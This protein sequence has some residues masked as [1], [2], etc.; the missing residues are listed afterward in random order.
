MLLAAVNTL[1]SLLMVAYMGAFGFVTD[2][3]SR[4]SALL[5]TA[6]T[7]LDTAISTHIPDRAGPTFNLAGTYVSLLDLLEA[8]R[9]STTKDQSESTSLAYQPAAEDV[10]D[11]SEPESVSNLDDAIVNL[12]CEI[13]NRSD[14]TKKGIS[15]TGFMINE[16]GV[17]LT[18][19]HVA[20]FLLLQNVP[21]LGEIECAM[22]T[23]ETTSKTYQVELLYISPTWIID[24]ADLISDPEPKGTGQNDFAL[25]YVTGAINGTDLPKEF[26]HLSLDTNLLST[27]LLDQTV[28]LAGFPASDT[29]EETDY[30][31]RQLATTTVPR[32][33]T[34]GS[35][36]ADLIVLAGSTIGAQGASGGP[37]L[38]AKGDVIGMITTRA[39]DEEFGSGSLRAITISYIHRTLEEETGFGLPETIIGDLRNRAKIFNENMTP[40]LTGL[41]ADEL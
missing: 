31:S 12:Y 21:Q 18:N 15:G 1:I 17:I 8:V 10:E 41:L 2:T 32:L 33:Y 30:K 22:R 19:A 29:E 23:G 11:Q 27:A 6:P 28:I 3:A 7:V 13:V 4:V 14:R 5:E 37:V 40:I 16:S 36:Y 20:Q 25:L 24:H 26:P 39:D 34:F 35:R 9:A 38:N